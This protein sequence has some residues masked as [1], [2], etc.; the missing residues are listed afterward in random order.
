MTGLVDERR[1]ADIIY[2][3]FRKALDTVSRKI[4][5]HKLLMYE[6]DEKD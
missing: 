5:I 3:D 6:L 2:L 1:A 4:L